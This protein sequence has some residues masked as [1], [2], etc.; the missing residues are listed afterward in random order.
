MKQISFLC[1]L[2]LSTVLSA[3]VD[4]HD[5]NQKSAKNYQRIVEQMEM[6]GIVDHDSATATRVQTVF[7]RLQQTANKY[8]DSGQALDWRIT[9]FRSPEVSAWTMPGGKM[10][11]YSSLVE[12]LRLNDDELSIILAHEMAHVIKEHGKAQLNVNRA[13]RLLSV[14][15]GA[16]ISSAVNYAGSALALAPEYAITRPFSRAKELEADRI[17]LLLMAESGYNPQ[18]AMRLWRKLYEFAGDGDTQG[19]L[20]RIRD[21][22]PG[23][24]EREANIQTV[25]PQAL[26]LYQQNRLNKP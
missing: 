14:F 10:I 25:F 9:V 2:A 13:T 23:Y 1:L 8:N 4:S 20:Q 21:T 19:F 22:H 11:V 3:C 5:L 17:G 18:A 26:A 16:A 6:F 24:A 12:K 15:G 7:A